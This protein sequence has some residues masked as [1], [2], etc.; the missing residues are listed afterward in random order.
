MPNNHVQYDYG[1]ARDEW[2]PSVADSIWH[3]FQNR[4]TKAQATPA[5]NEQLKRKPKAASVRSMID[6]IVK[7]SL[8]RAN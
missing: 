2:G 3:N 5:E 6:K 7:R 8:G 1:K 4:R